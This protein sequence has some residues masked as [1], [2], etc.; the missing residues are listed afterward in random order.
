MNLRK[1]PTVYL[2]AIAILSNHGRRID[3]SEKPSKKSAPSGGLEY[4]SPH[5]A[6]HFLTLLGDKICRTTE[7][8]KAWSLNFGH[9]RQQT[10]EIHYGKITNQRR[11]EI[12]GGLKK[13]NLMSDEVKDLLLD[14][15]E[16][17][18]TPGTKE[19]DTALAISKRRKR[20]KE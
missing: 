10:T 9:K 12:F 14:L 15:Y 4:F 19:H 8:G 11:G 6:K 20:R 7:E 16:Y 17:R 18:L 2:D 3:L 5:S 1:I 13:R